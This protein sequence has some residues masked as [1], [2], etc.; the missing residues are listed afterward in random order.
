[1]AEDKKP[2]LDELHTLWAAMHEGRL[3]YTK[4]SAL[5]LA[6]Q[7]LLAAECESVGALKNEVNIRRVEGALLKTLIAMPDDI[8]A[9]VESMLLEIEDIVPIQEY[10][11]AVRRKLDGSNN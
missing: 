2:T 1:M 6:G 4:E 3:E 10:K 5:T 7:L 11:E 8:V 9:E